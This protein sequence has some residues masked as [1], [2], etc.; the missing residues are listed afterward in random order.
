MHLRPSSTSRQALRSAATSHPAKPIILFDVM[1]VLIKDPFYTHMAAYFGM[2]SIKQLLDQKHPT[3]WIEFE[4]GEISEEEFFA[5]FF[6]D[7]RRFDG[8]GLVETMKTAYE[9]IE[10]MPELLE[11]LGQTYQLHT[12]SNYPNWHKH[13]E[14]KLKLSNYLEWTFVS[15]DGPMKGLR[16]PQ[17]EAFATAIKYFGRPAEE[18]IFID[19]R[20]ENVAAAASAGMQALHFTGLEEL[21]TAMRQRS[22]LTD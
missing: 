7:R 6:K 2:E 8:P 10:G 9:Y 19:D 11:T 4:R 5:K 1:G 16:K 21:K 15:C 14:A 13:I 20:K 17:P 12:F 22:I 18:L 3:A